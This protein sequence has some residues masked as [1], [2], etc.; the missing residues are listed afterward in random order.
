[1]IAHITCPVNF[2]CGISDRN[3]TCLPSCPCKDFR[4]CA[5]SC[6]YRIPKGL[7]DNSYHEAMARSQY[8]QVISQGSASGYGNQGMNCPPSHGVYMSTGGMGR[9][10]FK[11]GCCIVM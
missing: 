6:C 4:P 2:V 7:S 9:D 3:C 11:K 5:Q 10:D 8:S 1:M